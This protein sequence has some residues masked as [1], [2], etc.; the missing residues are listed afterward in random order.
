MSI[1]S[2]KDCNFNPVKLFNIIKQTKQLFLW[3]I[4]IMLFDFV[5]VNTRQA[6]VMYNPVLKRA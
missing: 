1:V 6:G 4:D 2:V 5:L 3:L